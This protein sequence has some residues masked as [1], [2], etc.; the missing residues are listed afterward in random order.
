[1]PVSSD[2]FYRALV[3]RGVSRRAF[4]KFS[5]AMASALALPASYGPRI[6]QALTTA[7]RVPV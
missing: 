4:L 5:A 3:E 6:A 2:P 7:K 1:M